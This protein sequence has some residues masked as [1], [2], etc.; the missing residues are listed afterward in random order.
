MAHDLF[1]TYERNLQRDRGDEVALEKHMEDVEESY[2]IDAAIDAKEF[3]ILRR[4]H[5]LFTGDAS[6]L[7][8]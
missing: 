8:P 1:T 6:L 5:F 2:Y 3:E 7:N 4:L